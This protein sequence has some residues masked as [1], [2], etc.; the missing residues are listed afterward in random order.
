MAIIA[1]VSIFVCTP[2]ALVFGIIARNQIKQSGEAG[3]GMA[4]AGIIVG[5]IGVAVTLLYI[6]FF[7]LVIGGGFANGY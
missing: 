6:G 5:A 7:V 1:L 3:S 4:L 2:A